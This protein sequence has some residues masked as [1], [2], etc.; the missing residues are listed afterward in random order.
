MISFAWEI[1]DAK[2]PWERSLSETEKSCVYLLTWFYLVDGSASSHCGHCHSSS[3]LLCSDQ[4]NVARETVPMRSWLEMRRAG[5][6]K[7]HFLP[8]PL[9]IPFSLRMEVVLLVSRR[10]SSKCSLMRARTVGG[11]NVSVDS[12]SASPARA[13]A[14]S[15]PRTQA[16][17]NNHQT[18]LPNRLNEHPRQGTKRHATG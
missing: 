13:S 12:F 2:V 15:F 9:G 3:A 14:R 18:R 4:R 8:A 6:R 10:A 16:C 17:P 7:S 1:S 5:P 11:S